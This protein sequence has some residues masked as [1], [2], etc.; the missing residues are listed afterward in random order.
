MSKKSVDKRKAKLKER[1]RHYQR[2]L[3]GGRAAE[4]PSL[5]ERMELFY[6]TREEILAEEQSTMDAMP[7]HTLR[8]SFF[9]EFPDATSM[10]ELVGLMGEAFVAYATAL[11]PGEQGI[12]LANEAGYSMRVA[13]HY[14]DTVYHEGG[15]HDLSIEHKIVNVGLDE[16]SHFMERLTLRAVC[17]TK[18]K[19]YTFEMNLEKEH[20][21]SKETKRNPKNALLAAL[22]CEFA[23]PVT[24]HGLEAYPAVVALKKYLF[25][26]CTYFVPSLPP[27]GEYSQ[28][29][30]AEADLQDL[31]ATRTAAGEAQARLA[32]AER[33]IKRLQALETDRR[34]TIDV[35][36]ATVQR[37]DRALAKAVQA[38]TMD[39]GSTEPSPP[40]AGGPELT[41]A[42]QDQLSALS[43]AHS[44]RKDEMSLMREEIYNLQSQLLLLTSA[45]RAAEDHFTAHASDPDDFE[46]LALWAQTEVADRLTIHPK[47]FATAAAS[48]YHN[49][50]KVYQALR[51]IAEAYW[52]MVY[53]PTE[54]ALA[55]W[56]QR[57]T[58]LGLECTPVGEAAV[59]PMTRSAYE[60]LHNGTKRTLNLHLRGNSSFD[61]RYGLRIYFTRLDEERKVLVGA[62]PAHLPN[63]MSN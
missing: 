48:N 61:S 56:Q 26:R 10:P 35:L 52:P 40:E 32:V 59:H 8:N 25:D 60:V 4:L 51:A 39:Q 36:Q 43:L 22:R 44:Q 28:A 49:P 16:E 5:N 30:T 11:F 6:G 24:S 50:L 9:S 33:E 23:E 19:P 62:F 34:N 42:L 18:N 13:D 58:E 57:C 41:Q 21:R 14:A 15:T 1:R 17:L 29:M 12:R 27:V 63:R 20:W 38:S 45:N 47:A 37:R 53:E 3:E 2:A 54:G 46:Q 31:V 55:R 7:A